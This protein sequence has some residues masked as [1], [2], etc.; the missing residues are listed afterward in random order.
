MTYTPVLTQGVAGP[1]TATFSQI[2]FASG[3]VGTVG[4]PHTIGI[5]G[6][7]GIRE[8]RKYETEEIGADL[9]GGAMVDAV[10]LGSRLYLEFELE[11]FNLIEVMRLAHPFRETAT[12][13]L[14]SQLATEGEFGTPGRFEAQASGQL[15][16]T[17]SSTTLHSAGAQTTPVRTYNL[18]KMAPGFEMSKLIASRRRVCPLRLQV[19]PMLD[20][21]S[22]K[23]VF[24]TKS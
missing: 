10:H 20:S 17:P 19:F 16:L 1:F 18:V 7:K 5:I 24:Y 6:S 2:T 15:I 9:L 13:T 21:G 14:A 23:Y 8:I 4:T 22:S 12:D 3:A 11:E